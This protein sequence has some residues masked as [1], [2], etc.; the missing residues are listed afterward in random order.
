MLYLRRKYN[1]PLKDESIS[2]RSKPVWKSVVKRQI[3]YHVFSC[4]LEGGHSNRKTVDSRYN[5]SKS[6]DNLTKLDP[7]VARVLVKVRLECL[8]EKSTS[9]RYI[10]TNLLIY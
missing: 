8:R 3:R 5:K 2:N 9:K 7:S 4:L 6:V 10:T 1:L